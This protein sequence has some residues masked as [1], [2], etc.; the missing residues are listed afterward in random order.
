MV[1]YAN[2]CERIAMATLLLGTATEHRAWVLCNRFLGVV[3]ILSP[4]FLY[5]VTSHLTATHSKAVINLHLPFFQSRTLSTIPMQGGERR[6]RK[7]T[8]KNNHG[9]G[10]FPPIT[11]SSFSAPLQH[12]PGM[13][14]DTIISLLREQAQGR[15]KGSNSI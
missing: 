7:R 11:R 9:L 2:T 6:R 10:A 8:Q 13:I 5:F 1:G 12:H 14:K 4:F 15:E 3:C